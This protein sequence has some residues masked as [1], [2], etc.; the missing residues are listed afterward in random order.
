MATKGTYGVGGAEKGKPGAAERGTRCRVMGD[1]GDRGK[2]GEGR[3]EEEERRGKSML[4]EGPEERRRK[5]VK[6]NGAKDTWGKQW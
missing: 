2:E 1:E 6:E 4:A 3:G 5:E